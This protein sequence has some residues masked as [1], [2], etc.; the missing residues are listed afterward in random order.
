MIIIKRIE[1]I[2]NEDIIAGT[3]VANISEKIREARLRLL[4]HVARNTEEI[5]VMRTWKMEVGE[6]RDIGRRKLV[7]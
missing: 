3:G 2:R 5:V 1:K 6:H 7:E 4:G